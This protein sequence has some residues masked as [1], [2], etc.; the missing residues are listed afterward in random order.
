MLV[1]AEICATDSVCLHCWCS[2]LFSM[3]LWTCSVR[4]SAAQE[5]QYRYFIG[6]I[7]DAETDGESKLV[8]VRVWETNLRPRRFSV[9]SK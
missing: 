8:M 1:L 5:I 7:Q 4:L 3:E 6:H 2:R 9:K